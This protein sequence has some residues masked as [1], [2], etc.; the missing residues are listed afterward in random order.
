M[1]LKK[2]SI[3]PDNE[4]DADIQDMKIDDEYAGV[5][6]KGHEIDDE[7]HPIHPVGSEHHEVLKDEKE[8]KAV[9]ASKDNQIVLNTV[10]G[11][12]AYVILI[13]ALYLFWTGHNAP[14]GGFIAG[15]M[16]AAVVVLLYVSYGSA[17]IKNTLKFDFKY[18]IAIGLSLSLGCGIGGIIVGEPFLTHTFFE[19]HSDIFCEIEFATATIFDLG[20]YLTVTGGCVTIITSIGESGGKRVSVSE[21]ISDKPRGE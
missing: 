19:Y 3:E 4:K 16:T 13:F 20:V 21:K 7:I 12:V 6:E 10:V 5:D 11:A 1:S 9:T 2:K 15:L 8:L 14:G 18:L 17:F